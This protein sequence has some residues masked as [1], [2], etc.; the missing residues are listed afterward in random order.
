[1]IKPAWKPW[2]QV[3]RLRDDVR[4]GE[5]SLQMFAADLYDVAMGQ[6]KPVYQDRRSSSRSR[7]LQL[8]FAIWSK[9]C[10]VA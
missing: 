3:V 9:T 4:S 6:A 5:L 7:T 2:H 1:M 8:S 10:C